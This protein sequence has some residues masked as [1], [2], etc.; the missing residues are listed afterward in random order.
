MK[1]K[2][3]TFVDIVSLVFLLVLLFS[4]FLALLYITQGNLVFSF[5]GSAFLC[6]LYFFVIEQMRKNKEALIRQGYKHFSLLFIG[7]FLILTFVSFIFMS[8]FINVEFN[9]KKQV[10]EEAVAKI[11]LVQSFIAEY[12]NRSKTDLQ[13]LE[14]NLAQKMAPALV[15]SEITPYAKKTEDAKKYLEKEL[16]QNNDKFNKVFQNW[17]RLS[18]MQTYTNLNNYVENSLKVVNEK[19]AEL[20]LDKSP[21]VLQDFD[22]NTLPLNSPTQLNTKFK[23][24]YILSFIVILVV[25][26]G[27]LL[28]YILHT[29]RGSGK[30]FEL[31]E[32]A[33]KLVREIK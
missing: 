26:L 14:S 7:F 27:L 32:Q 4:N 8:H 6:V 29:T 10:Q 15:I 31:S 30:T 2:N 3:Y 11:N 12:E 24:N 28:S 23:P 17:K 16:T 18:V 20:P 33:K 19:L 5:I 1:Q 22:K 25:H 13:N 21:I 9:A